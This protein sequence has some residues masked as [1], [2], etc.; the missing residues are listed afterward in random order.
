MTR[1]VFL[2]VKKCAELK[3]RFEEDLNI[4]GLGIE[5]YHLPAI[6]DTS[7]LD[8]LADKSMMPQ[9]SPT[10][11]PA[12]NATRLGAAAGVWP[13][14]AFHY[15]IRPRRV[16][17][18]L[19]TSRKCQ[20][21][22]EWFSGFELKVIVAGYIKMLTAPAHSAAL[23][24]VTRNAMQLGE[25]TRTTLESGSFFFVVVVVVVV[26]MHVRSKHVDDGYREGP[27]LPPEWVE[28]PWEEKAEK[29]IV[30][31]TWGRKDD[32][33]A[34]TKLT[35]AEKELCVRLRHLSAGS[36]IGFCFFPLVRERKPR[37]AGWPGPVRKR[38][39]PATH[40]LQA[41]V[42]LEGWKDEHW[43]NRLDDAAHGQSAEMKNTLQP[44]TTCGTDNGDLLE[45]VI[46]MSQKWTRAAGRP[47]FP[48]GVVTG[49][50]VSKL[51][52]PMKDEGADLTVCL[53]DVWIP[54]LV[55]K[56]HRSEPKERK[57][58][59]GLCTSWTLETERKFLGGNFSPKAAFVSQMKKARNL[60]LGTR[61][62]GAGS[63]V[64]NVLLGDDE[65]W[66]T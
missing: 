44:S 13:K 7:R 36:N 18:M 9:A 32:G 56:R 41:S 58:D 16:D 12:P 60:S 50:R 20:K 10:C 6:D 14:D 1:S 57:R 46:K 38:I 52:W 35:R 26:S 37:A 33:D 62:G 3:K 31:S 28:L 17:S 29:N 53:M 66:T 43:L 27:T 64:A 2:T 51:S 11:K 5:L 8:G 23:E 47:M 59:R 45:V 61:R 63:L 24:S 42:I 30:R 48:T 54:N 25:T 19:E 39:K 15:E 34:D 49:Q 65:G 40:G 55:G 22:R 21:L 4:N